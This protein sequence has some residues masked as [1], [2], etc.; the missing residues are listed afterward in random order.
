[1]ALSLRA[2]AGAVVVLTACG[3]PSFVGGGDGGG[4]SDG[5][6]TSDATT[7]D[8]AAEDGGVDGAAPG[9]I[10][11]PGAPG[12]SC[13][14]KSICCLYR[15]SSGNGYVGSCQPGPKC[16][17]P[18]PAGTSGDPPSQFACTRTTQCTNLT[19]C[20]IVR[21][22]GGGGGVS[23]SS[24]QPLTMCVSSKGAVLCEMAHPGCPGGLNGCGTGS[25]G[26]W[27]IPQDLGT[28]GGAPP[29]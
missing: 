12:G 14:I 24:C 26:D 27:G 1:M 11:C 20:C 28:C 19:V 22:G 23:T 15:T 18:A 13:E 2:L 29:G 4:G 25:N 5:G 17:G 10:D 8:G 7:N 16:A 6:A 9:P 3:S 21:S